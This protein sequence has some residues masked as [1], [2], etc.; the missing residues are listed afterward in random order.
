MGGSGSGPYGDGGK[1][2]KST[3]EKSLSLDANKLKAELYDDNSFIW[4]WSWE[5]GVAPWIKKEKSEVAI[6]IE[7]ELMILS[8]S[9]CSNK[10]LDPVGITWTKCNYGGKRPWF[11]CPGCTKRVG[12]LYLKNGIFR[13]RKCNDLTYKRCQI[14]GNDFSVITERMYELADRLQLKDFKVYELDRNYFKPKGMHQKTF[15]KLSEEL[16]LLGYLRIIALDKKYK[17]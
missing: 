11:L 2:A 8:Y 10:Y 15:Y 3:V 16:E 13:C 7:K 5:V 12:K 17:M 4:S 9:T 14:S 1:I 6:F